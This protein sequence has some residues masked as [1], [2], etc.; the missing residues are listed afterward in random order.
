M[1]ISGAVGRRGRDSGAR[2]ALRDLAR[3]A[4][5]PNWRNDCSPSHEGHAL[6]QWAA[7]T[8]SSGER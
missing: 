5:V 6:G 1:G 2:K 8:V 3:R 7:T 4:T